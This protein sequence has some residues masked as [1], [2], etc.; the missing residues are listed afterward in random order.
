MS[1]NSP[2][3][4]RAPGL[5][6]AVNKAL[7]LTVGKDTKLAGVTTDSKSANTGR[8]GGLWRLLTDQV[9]RRLATFLCAAHRSDLVIESVVSTV[10]EHLEV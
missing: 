8:Q 10:P 4:N 2:E 9:H 7:Y 3:K 5:L 1:C 6:E